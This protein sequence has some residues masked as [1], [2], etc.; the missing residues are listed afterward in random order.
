M[1]KYE[2]INTGK[3]IT[4]ATLLISDDISD[5]SI[6]EIFSA[7]GKFLAKGTRYQSWIADWYDSTGIAHKSGTGL[8]VCF[9][10]TD[11]PKESGR[12][13]PREE[14]EPTYTAVITLDELCEL[15]GVLYV[16]EENE[17]PLAE[18]L[19]IIKERFK[20]NHTKNHTK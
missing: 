2:I 3:V 4:L 5:Q 15:A 14:E 19:R 13:P 6:I 9:K 12:L 20:R 7:E 11:A 18:K 8:T 10:I 17:S 16:L 1:K